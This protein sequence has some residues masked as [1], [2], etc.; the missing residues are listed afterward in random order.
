MLSIFSHWPIVVFT[1]DLS[2]QCLDCGLCFAVLP[3]LKRHLFVVHK[4]RDFTQY[5]EETGCVVEQC[6]GEG[7]KKTSPQSTL[8]LHV[9]QIPNGIAQPNLER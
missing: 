3:S 8:R 4:V 1:D 6:N 2:L 7:L 5:Q 9:S